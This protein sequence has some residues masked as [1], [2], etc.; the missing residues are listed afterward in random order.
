MSND[1]LW[2]PRPDVPRA[3]SFE[4]MFCGDPTCGLHIL[5]KSENGEALCEIVMSADVTL[6]MIELCKGHLYQ[7][8]VDREEGE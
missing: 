1:G 7:K 6:E 2:R 5:A 8:A 3:E 4:M